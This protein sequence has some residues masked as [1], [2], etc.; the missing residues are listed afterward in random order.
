MANVVDAAEEAVDIALL[1][2]DLDVLADGDQEG[3][4]TFAK[5]SRYEFMTAG[6][7]FGSMFS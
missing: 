3:R 1:R 6:T 4:V 7:N 2:K 5:T